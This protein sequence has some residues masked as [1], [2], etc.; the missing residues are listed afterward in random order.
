M[1]HELGIGTG[2]DSPSVGGCGRSLVARLGEENRFPFISVINLVNSEKVLQ[3]F[4]ILDLIFQFLIEFG[5]LPKSSCHP[6]C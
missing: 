6:H 4:G 1:Q 2:S 5:N 3:S